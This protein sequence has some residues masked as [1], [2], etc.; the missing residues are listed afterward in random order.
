M[1]GSSPAYPDTHPRA[2]SSL[3]RPI[4]PCHR[5]KLALAAVTLRTPDKFTQLYD[6]ITFLDLSSA[7]G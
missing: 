7:T 3:D 1:P 5:R 2:G 4:T 6:F